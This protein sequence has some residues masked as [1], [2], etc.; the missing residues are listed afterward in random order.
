[1]Q[2]PGQAGHPPQ[3][4]NRQ[5]VDEHVHVDVRE[6]DFLILFLADRVGHSS[7]SVTNRNIYYYCRL[8]KIAKV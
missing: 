7:Y 3:E 5:G 1:M 8:I 2:R 4:I 6:V